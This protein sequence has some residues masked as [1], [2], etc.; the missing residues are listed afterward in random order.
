[1]KVSC[2]SVAMNHSCVIRF[3][4]ARG[5]FIDKIGLSLLMS[6]I[7]HVPVGGEACGNEKGPNKKGRGKS[8]QGEL[9]GTD[10]S[11]FMK[12]NRAK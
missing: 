3:A 2:Y 11:L 12:N 1:M 9:H 8:K 6:Y 10:E 5:E 7:S 4:T